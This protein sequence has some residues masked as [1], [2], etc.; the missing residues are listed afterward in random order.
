MSNSQN[1]SE[2]STNNSRIVHIMTAKDAGKK[3]QTENDSIEE[4][5]I[6]EDETEANDVS[7]AHVVQTNN[8]DNTTNLETTENEVEQL[9]NQELEEYDVATINANVQKLNDLATKYEESAKQIIEA[10]TY[11]TANELSVLGIG[12]E[13]RIVE[14]ANNYKEIAKKL[15][16]Y[17]KSLEAQLQNKKKN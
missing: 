7:N 6:S 2:G 1:G 12:L 17:A 14:C 4:R 3:I 10:S 16:E 13:D 8:Q 15:R 5:R 9:L 11:C